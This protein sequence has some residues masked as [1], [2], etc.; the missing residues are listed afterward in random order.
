MAKQDKKKGSAFSWLALVFFVLVFG[1]IAWVVNAGDNWNG[2]NAAAEAEA[3]AAAAAG[4]AVIDGKARPFSGD[5]YI[6]RFGDDFDLGL[7]SVDDLGLSVVIAMDKSGSMV[8]PPETGLR[9][10]KFIQASRALGQ[11]VDFL[12]KNFSGQA[13]N[14]LVL[15]VGIIGFYEEV[16]ELFPLT[17][18]DQAGFAALR[19]VVDNPRSFEPG[20]KTAIGGALERGA[21]TLAQSGTILKSLIVVSDG[22]NNIEPEPVDVM[23]A[24]TGN[25]NDAS[26]VDFPVGTNGTIVSFVGFDIDS[27]LFGDLHTAGARITSA[28]DQTELKT[29]LQQILVA[30]ITRLEASGQ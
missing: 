3:Q 5:G 10:P 9:D 14:G 25:R 30:D 23:E 8:D 7:S 18:M 26:T 27:G 24:I 11:I 16:E 6:M 4:G 15:K 19:K 13:A 12:E 1:G 28:A 29:A 21:R 2:D 20:G 22:E 17:I